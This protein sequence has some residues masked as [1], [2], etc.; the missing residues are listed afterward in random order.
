MTTAQFTIPGVY[1]EDVFPQE[2]P[3]LP[4]GVPVFIGLS[5]NAADRQPGSADPQ[6][7]THWPQFHKQVDPLQ[8]D[9]LLAAAVHGFFANGGTLCYVIMPTMSAAP[10]LETGLEQALEAV[11]DITDIDLVCVPELVNRAQTGTERVRAQQLIL[12]HCDRVNSRFAILDTPLMTP[13]AALD[14]IPQQAQALRGHNG[15]LYGPWI[16]PERA[17][18]EVPWVPPCGHVAGMIARCDRTFGVHRAPANLAIADALD[19]SLALSDADQHRLSPVDQPGGVNFLRIFPGRGMRVWGARTLS[20]DPLSRYVSARRLV[21]TVGRW[22]TLNLAGVAFEPNDFTLWVRI[23]R[24]LTV[25]LESLAQ[26]G[27]LQGA[28]AETAFFVKCDADTNPPAVRDRGQIVTLVG[29]AAAAPGEFI[30]VRLIH[31]E[32]GVTL[33][34]APNL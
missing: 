17:D 32:T 34:S 16:K 15:A 1:R 3:V 25:Y 10:P 18:P 5:G 9:P 6:R 21:I 26:Q 27:A 28:S 14:A 11:E 8:P 24:E 2:R 31:G 7:L 13:A 33:T 23:E 19:L 20:P 30:V 4:T 12:D 29:L 22:A